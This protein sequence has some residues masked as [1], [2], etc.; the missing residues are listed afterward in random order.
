MRMGRGRRPARAER[1]KNLR[2]R[3]WGEGLRTRGRRRAQPASWTCEHAP[4]EGRWI[5]FAAS[6]I[7]SFLAGFVEEDAAPDEEN[8]ANRRDS[9]ADEPVPCIPNAAGQAHCAV[10]RRPKQRHER[11]ADAKPY[12]VFLQAVR[13]H[14]MFVCQGWAGRMSAG[15]ARSPADGGNDGLLPR[16][17]GMAP[18]A[19]RNRESPPVKA[20]AQD[21]QG[22]GAGAPR[23]DEKAK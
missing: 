5:R 18:A 8:G 19:M 1:A 10:I 12:G 15:M 3:A 16:L 9:A 11:T 13:L 4:C 20:K 6:R 22:G 2:P 7:L 23:A 17:P 21:L 14:R